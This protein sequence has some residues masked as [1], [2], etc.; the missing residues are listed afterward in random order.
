MFGM[1]KSKA[2]SPISIYAARIVIEN[3]VKQMKNEGKYPIR[4]ALRSV[5]RL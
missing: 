2:V 5:Q 1:T 4:R 3:A